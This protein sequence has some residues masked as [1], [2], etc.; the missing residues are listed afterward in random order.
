MALAALD[1]A[2]I[3]RALALVAPQADDLA[4][5]YFEERT[6][7]ELPAAD[8]TVGLRVWRERGLAVRLLRG[9]RSW[10]ASRDALD[11]AALAD[12]L[13]SVARA[14]PPAFPSPSPPPEAAEETA[15]LDELASFAGRLELALRHRFLAFPYRLT[16]RWHARTSRVVT[17]RTASEVESERFAS[18]D[19]RTPWGR[20]GALA[21]RLDDG[22]AE[23][24]AERLAARFRAR[25][26]SPPAAGR[27]P[28]LLRPAATAVLLHE[29]VAHA[30]ECDLLARSGSPLAA[31][32]VELGPA[33]LDV[34]DDPAAAPASVARR[35]DDEGSA[36]VR[37]WLLRRG[38][39]AQ[40]IADLRG[41]RRWSELLPGS[42]FRAD[43]HA[44]P[45]PRSHHLELLAGDAGDE[46]LRELAA[47]GLEIAE[48][49]SGAL[50]PASG[51][52]VLEIPCAR[53]LAGGEAGDAVGPFRV[54]A[55]LASLL[56]G[57]VAVGE[58]RESAGAGWCAKAGQ[59]RAV[60]A[61]APAIVLAGL[62]VAP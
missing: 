7:A 6:E 36:T 52:V 25:D 42:G 13:R 35:A 21:P 56:G 33:A 38:R 51:A 24:L 58:R 62:E 12:A 1:T 53:R 43:R 14:V 11:A 2:A 57:V 15:P 29:C 20:A 8:A 46:R 17:P 45:L 19:V 61:T 4:D 3:A 18:V 22:A 60:W 50:D 32:G 44:P 55:H 10:L 34:L 30:L 5:A 37:R 40:P 26:A 16:V 59:R 47:G 39:V 54:H 9:E 41:A 28:L 23:R 49:G 48:I 31:D 27:P